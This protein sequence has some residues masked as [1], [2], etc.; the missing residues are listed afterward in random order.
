M[1]SS[2]QNPAAICWGSE[3]AT[4]QWVHDVITG[5]GA[6]A[7]IVRCVTAGALDAMPVN[8]A[9][10]RVLANDLE[11]AASSFSWDVTNRTVT[12]NLQVAYRQAGLPSG[13]FTSP[14]FTARVTLRNP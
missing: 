11:G 2:C 5:V 1:E 9:G 4:G 10:C 3:A 7:Q 14:P 13:A 12:L 6:D 8:Y